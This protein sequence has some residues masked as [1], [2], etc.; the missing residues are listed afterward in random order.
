MTL[1]IH[2]LRT[3]FTEWSQRNTVYPNGRRWPRLSKSQRSVVAELLECTQARE[4][5]PDYRFSGLNPVERMQVEAVAYELLKCGAY[6]GSKTDAI[7]DATAIVKGAT[8][9][10]PLGDN[11]HNAAACPYCTPL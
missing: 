10:P 3:A 1:S 6:N 4:T 8:F 5:F 7:T 11:H 2:E 9:A